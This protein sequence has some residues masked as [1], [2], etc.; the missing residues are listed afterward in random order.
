MKK[1]ILLL[2]RDS[3]ENNC[4]RWRRI[5]V[6]IQGASKG[7]Y[8]SYVTFGATRETD[9]KTSKVGQLLLAASLVTVCALSSVFC[10]AARDGADSTEYKKARVKAGD[11]KEDIER[12]K[13]EAALLEKREKTLLSELDNL[14]SLINLQNTRLDDLTRTLKEQEA[15]CREMEQ[16]LLEFQ[17]R[18]DSMKSQAR[19]RIVSYYKFGPVGLMNL[20]FNSQS[21]PDLFARQE[22]LRFMLRKDMQTISVFQKQA[23]LL[24]QKQ[25]EASQAGTQAERVRNDIKIETEKLEALHRSKS[26]LLVSVHRRKQTCLEDIKELEKSAERINETIRT[27]QREKERKTV[28]DRDV[29]S[30]FAALRGKLDPPVK[31]GRVVGLFGR[32]RRTLPGVKIVRSGIDIQASAGTEIRSIYTGRV[33]YSGYL[34]GYGNVLILDHADKYYSL[35]AQ[36][37]RFHKQVGNLV[38][39][40]EVIGV[41]AES[42]DSLFGENLY[43]EI[44]HGGKPQN[45]LLWI[46]G[47]SLAFD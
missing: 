11:L 18:I 44:R 10:L 6:R 9:Q 5:L 1:A 30:G 13:G 47:A 45:P 15:E 4:S 14:E 3:A 27:L 12:K 46:N 19:S 24:E 7:A 35:Y 37:S 21:V 42:G 25:K 20:L 33:I 28:P 36:A 40:A 16:R 17:D 2:L 32:E 22:G 34:K 41:I 31:G 26:D 23:D 8:L 39:R 43:F 29:P 38:K